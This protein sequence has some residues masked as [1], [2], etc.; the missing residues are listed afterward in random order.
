[1]LISHVRNIHIGDDVTCPICNQVFQEEEQVT[2]HMNSV[3]V[4]GNMT[5]TSNKGKENEKTSTALPTCEQCGY[6]TPKPSNLKR[7]ISLKHSETQ[8]SVPN[9][10]NKGSKC[11]I[12]KA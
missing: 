10:T 12:T 5:Y 6:T 4:I 9:T 3:H 1:M 7:H 2:L 8:E 11:T